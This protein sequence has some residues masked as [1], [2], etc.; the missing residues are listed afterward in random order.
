[1][2]FLPSFNQPLCANLCFFSSI[3]SS[4]VLFFISGKDIKIENKFED[5]LENGMTENDAKF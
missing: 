2:S 5:Q 4:S 1:M 3:I